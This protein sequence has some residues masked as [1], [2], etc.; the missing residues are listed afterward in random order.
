[1]NNANIF[2]EFVC[3][4]ECEKPLKLALNP[5]FFLDGLRVV[6]EDTVKLRCIDKNSPINMSFGDWKYIIMPMRK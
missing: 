4:H 1:E 5:N 3:E 2:S 6:Y